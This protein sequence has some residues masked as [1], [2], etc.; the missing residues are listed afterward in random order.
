MKPNI[1]LGDESRV[2][3]I[4]TLNTIL[5]TAHVLY[6]KTR[7]YHWNVVGPEFHSLHEMFEQQYTQ[8][9]ENI[10]EIAERVRM[11]GGKSLGTMAEFIEK[12]SISEEA[13]RVYPPAHDMVVNLVEG[14]ETVI[15]YLREQI[16]V[17]DEDCGDVGTADFLTGLLEQ[18][19]KV[20]WMLRSLVE[21]KAVN[22]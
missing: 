9:A 22:Q 20:A 11:L 5:A 21:G 8:L 3:I 2:Q 16:P 18:H 19:E 7:N 12:S 10:D 4:D 15:R 13:P 6:V 1:G 17:I 14:H